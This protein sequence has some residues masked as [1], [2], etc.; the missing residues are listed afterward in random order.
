LLLLAPVVMKS[1]KSRE[2]PAPA[3]F[4][5]VSSGRIAVKVSGDVRFPGIY[6]VPANSMA[7]SVIKMAVPLQPLLQNSIVRNGDQTVNNGAAVSFVTLSDGSF[8]VI[9]GGMTVQ[10]R[11]ILNIPLDISTMSD[12]DFELLPGIGPALVGRIIEFRQKNGGMLRIE[13]LAT[14][15]GIG[16]KKYAL[17][18]TY[19]Q[20]IV[21]TK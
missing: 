18:R 21:N 15:D 5:M 12:A 11:L 17:L 1:R 13:D 14:I 10:E 16:K 9:S 7:L 8:R 3:A 6:E 19:F 20:P 4:Y 2:T